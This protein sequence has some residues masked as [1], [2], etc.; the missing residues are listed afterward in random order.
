VRI[1]PLIPARRT[2]VAE[3]SAP[4]TVL[5]PYPPPCKAARRRW[6]PVAFT[7]VGNFS[8]RVTE[9]AQFIIV[10]RCL[11]AGALRRLAFTPVAC[12]VIDALI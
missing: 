12:P 1:V 10:G 8:G 5:A 4:L 6:K 2:G 11:Q 7:N 9:D 3:D